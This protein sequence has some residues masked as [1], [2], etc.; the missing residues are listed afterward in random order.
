MDRSAPYVLRMKNPNKEFPKGV[1][2]VTCMIIFCAL[3]GIVALSIMFGQSG[4]LMNN[5]F[6]T[7]G[8][9]YAFQKLGQY[10]GIGNF[11]MVIYSVCLA[12]A[13]LS[14]LIINVDLANRILVGNEDQRFFPKFTFKKNK[15]GVYSFWLKTTVIIVVILQIIPCFGIENT[16]VLYK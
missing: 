10:F 16:D 13:C 5:D 9:F 7:N 11:F 15:N 14:S 12:V 3:F 8:Q 6:L 4:E 2:L 1:I